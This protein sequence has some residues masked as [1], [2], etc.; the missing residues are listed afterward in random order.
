MT[1]STPALWPRD[2]MPSIKD[3]VPGV[4]AGKVMAFHRYGRKLLIGADYGRA[5]RFVYHRSYYAP[6]EQWSL[7]TEAMREAV[8]NLDP[9]DTLLS[10]FENVPDA[11]FVD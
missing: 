9:Y 1:A 5:K 11:D 7:Y 3:R 10:Y 4:R 8:A 2:S 6:G